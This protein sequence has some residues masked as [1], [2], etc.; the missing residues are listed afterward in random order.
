MS[1]ARVASNLALFHVACHLVEFILELVL[2]KLVTHLVGLGQGD[3]SFELVTFATESV[4][5][6]HRTGVEG[7]EA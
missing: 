6:A 1:L 2:V 7:V 3:G 5:H 4:N